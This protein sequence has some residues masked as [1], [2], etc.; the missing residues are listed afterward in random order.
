MTKPEH[1]IKE[2]LELGEKRTPGKWNIEEDARATS[3]IA[4]NGDA[5]GCS[6]T[7][8]GIPL[9]VADM[10]YIAAAPSMEAWLREVV[11]LLPELELNLRHI[12][13]VSKDGNT[14]IVAKAALDNLQDL[15]KRMGLRDD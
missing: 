4:D 8:E 9:E 14:W 13:N 2:I 3:L 11:E 15:M 7:H 10:E 5:L 12:L 1:T 6:A